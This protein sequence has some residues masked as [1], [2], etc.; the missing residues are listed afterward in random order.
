MG[1]QIPIY[2]MKINE[3][4]LDDIDSNELTVSADDVEAD[5]QEVR[6]EDFPIHFIFY[7]TRPGKNIADSLKS[8]IAVC[9]KRLNMFFEGHYALFYLEN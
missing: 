9:R 2:K 4:Y 7:A 3:D 6:E 8:V 5:V 1:K